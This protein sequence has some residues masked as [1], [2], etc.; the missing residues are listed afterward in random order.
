MNAEGEKIRRENLDETVANVCVRINPRRG[1]QRGGLRISGLAERGDRACDEDRPG[2][3]HQQQ[4]GE[5]EKTL[6]HAQDI[7][8]KT[9]KA[10]PKA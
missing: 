6:F 1:I 2:I 4:G 10:R 7:L 8:K 3:R 9:S 5:E